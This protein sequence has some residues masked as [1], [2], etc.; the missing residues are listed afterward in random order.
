MGERDGQAVYRQ[1]V[2]DF[3]QRVQRKAEEHLSRCLAAED[4]PEEVESP[5]YA[6]FC[7]CETCIVREVL[8]VCWDEMLEE[9]R[10]VVATERPAD[11]A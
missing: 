2:D 1:A 11:T 5:A 7:G 10:R 3:S 8:L 9:A 4:E 6:P